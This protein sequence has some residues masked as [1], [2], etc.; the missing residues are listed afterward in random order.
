M[1]TKSYEEL[2]EEYTPN[3][4]LLF[5]LSIQKIKTENAAKL[6]TIF[7]NIYT[8]PI[9]NVVAKNSIEI[10]SPQNLAN[11]LVNNRFDF[12]WK[13]ISNMCQLYK[14]DID[15]TIKFFFFNYIEPDQLDFLNQFGFMCI[16]FND[17]NW[18]NQVVNY[19]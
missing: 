13:K 9:L 5:F 12:E 8:P 16:N 4:Y 3:E 18:Y 2:I 6:W 11:T 14:N 1:T 15:K 17:E 10:C 7:S 19:V